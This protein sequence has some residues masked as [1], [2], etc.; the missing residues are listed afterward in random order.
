MFAHHDIGIQ[1]LNIG[2]GILYIIIDVEIIDF[3]QVGIHKGQELTVVVDEDNAERLG[4]VVN[5]QG[6]DGCC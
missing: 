4:L 1:R 2:K 3:V 6:L 5:L